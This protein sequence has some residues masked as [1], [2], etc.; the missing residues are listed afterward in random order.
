MNRFFLGHPVCI[1]AT[2]LF[3]IALGIL[4]V[5]AWRVRGE[6]RIVRDLRDQDLS[7]RLTAISSGDNWV[8]AHDAGRVATQ[9]LHALDELPQTLLQTR[10]LHRLRDLLERQRGRTTT[11]QLADDQRELA[12]RDADQAHDS[13]QLIRIIIW[14]IP[15]LGF[16]GTVVGITQTLGDLDFTDGNA[17]VDKLK[18]GLYVAFDTT[19]LGLVLSVVAIFLQYPVERA[20]QSLL[21]EIDSRIN[22][23]LNEKLP[24]TE[25]QDNP[26][27]HIAELCEG[28]RVAVAESL[29]SQTKL[30]R[31]T[32]DEAHSHWQQIA[33]DHGDRIGEALNQHL[34]PLLQRHAVAVDQ[35]AQALTTQVHEIT[36]HSR[37]WNRIANWCENRWRWMKNMRS[38]CVT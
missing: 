33:A 35:Q 15:M 2:L 23:L 31:Q 37:C 26:A 1:G 21:G 32:I 29:E 24:S 16:L 10:I 6:G 9:W 25:N 12:G 19:A 11:R 36:K 4:I 27:A 28:I 14:A 3:G 13:L 7:P 38:P 18:S 22:R 30:W 17:A 5:K 8:L 34:D 20:E